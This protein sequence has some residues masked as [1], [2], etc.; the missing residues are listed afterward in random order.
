M[1]EGSASWQQWGSALARLLRRVAGRQRPQER[2]ARDAAAAGRR[3]PGDFTGMPQITYAPR[4]DARPDA[5]EVVWA[6]V[7]FEEDHSQGKDRP[8]L[9]I[10]HDG[11]WLL[12]LPLTSKDHD[13]DAR[14]EAGRGRRWVDIGSGGWDRQRRPSEARVDR[15]IRIDPRTVRRI[16]SVLDRGRF[17]AVAAAVQRRHDGQR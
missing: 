12:G 15:V 14:Q 5:G 3:Y 16:G 4:D 10:G 8:V 13:V 1:A 9:L 2:A 6:W 17:D 11:K 7:P